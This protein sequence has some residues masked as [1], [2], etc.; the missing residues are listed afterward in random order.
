MK[1]RRLQAREQP[2]KTVDSPY[3]TAKEAVEYLRLGSLSALYRLITEHGLPHGRLG[4]HHRFD[5]RELDAFVRGF[6][7]AIEMARFT[8]KSA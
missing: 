4:R 8:K 2:A 7:S 5:K 1:R 3:L 6:D